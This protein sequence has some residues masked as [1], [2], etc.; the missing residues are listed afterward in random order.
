VQRRMVISYRRFGTTYGSHL[1]GSRKPRGNSCYIGRP[2]AQTVNGRP[3]TLDTL[4]RSPDIV[5]GIYGEQSGS[6]T[7]LS[8]EFCS[9]SLPVS[10]RQS[11]ILFLISK[12]PLSEGRA[13]CILRGDDSDSTY[14]RCSIMAWTRL[15]CL[16]RTR[17]GRRLYGVTFTYFR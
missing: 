1:Q 11:S 8:F 3:V 17:E 15:R 2:I 16:E 14:L 9:F 7:G 10:F 13:C 5:G 12:L 6:A 4:A